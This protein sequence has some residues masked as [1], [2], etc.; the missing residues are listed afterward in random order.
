MLWEQCTLLTFGNLG[1]TPFLKNKYL[2]EENYLHSSV[3]LKNLENAFSHNF[4]DLSQ[5][6]YHESRFH[7]ASSQCD[8]KETDIWKIEFGKD[9]KK[10]SPISDQFS[11]SSFAPARRQMLLIKLLAAAATAASAAFTSSY[12]ESILA[13]LLKYWQLAVWLWLLKIKMSPGYFLG[14]ERVSVNCHVG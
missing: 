10:L 8:Q 6:I 9:D 13:A 3:Y 11:P 1:L 5:L 4:F 2:F 14:R 7:L 12:S